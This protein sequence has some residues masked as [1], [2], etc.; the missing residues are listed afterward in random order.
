MIRVDLQSEPSDFDRLVRQVGKA[1]LKSSPQPKGNEWKRKD[2]WR[3]AIPM[4]RNSYNEICSYCCHWIPPDTGANTI[5]HFKPKDIHPSLAYEWEN[6]RLA[7]GT[8]N[9]R[10]G[11]REDILDPCN[12]EN[13]WFVI[14]FP[15]L[16][17][18]PAS[19]LPPDLLAAVQRTIDV[20]KLNDE[21]TCLQ[22]RQGY[23][24]DYCLG[25]ID[26]LHLERKAPFVALELRRQN[27][28]SQ[29]KQ[30][31]VYI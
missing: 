21:G 4:M 31:M 9:G 30:M 3:K 17:V 28:V 16:L 26:F 19:D 10:K 29:I 11:T 8:L 20:L 14:D 18:K 23:V 2:F 12:I 6:L 27:L 25:Q 15:S 7:S 13:G 24:K 22:G 1:F 5:E